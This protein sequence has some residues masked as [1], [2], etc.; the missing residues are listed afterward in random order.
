M[1]GTGIYAV[2]FLLA[3]GCLQAQQ[4]LVNYVN[5][6]LGTA[7]LWDSTDLGFKPTNS[8]TKFHITCLQILS[9][10]PK[11]FARNFWSSRPPIAA[12]ASDWMLA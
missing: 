7:I 2:L 3:T 6:F 9:A 12:F 8:F 11:V 4:Q 1:K 10:L 5:P